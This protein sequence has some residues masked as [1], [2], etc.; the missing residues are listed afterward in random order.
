M[1]NKKIILLLA[2]LEMMA[3]AILVVLYASQKITMQVFIPLL[4]LVGTVFSFAIL[5][6][7][8]KLPFK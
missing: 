7:L 8:K 2:A 5:A 6:A 1:N 3:L 4:V